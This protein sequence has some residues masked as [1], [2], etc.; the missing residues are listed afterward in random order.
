MSASFQGLN[1]FETFAAA[2]QLVCHRIYEAGE[3][4]ID[5]PD[6][7]LVSPSPDH[8]QSA[9]PVTAARVTGLATIVSN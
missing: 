7:K 9:P 3:S 6:G 8:R 4:D 1:I 5:C 2:A